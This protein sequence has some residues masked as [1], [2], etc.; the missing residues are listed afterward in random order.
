MMRILC[1]AAG[2]LLALAIAPPARAQV[3]LD[4][5]KITCDQFTGYKITNPQNI[6]IYMTNVLN[7]K[8]TSLISMLLSVNLIYDDN[9]KSVKSDGTPA[10][11]ALQ[12]QETVGIGLAYKFAKKARKPVPPPPPPVATPPAG[13]SGE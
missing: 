4:M 11:P 9:I 5:A 1:V 8:V 13:T 6:A 2:M 12:L 7:V 10:G 3:T